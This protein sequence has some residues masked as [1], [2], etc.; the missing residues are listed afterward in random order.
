MFGIPGMGPVHGAV[1]VGAPGGSMPVGAPPGK[2]VFVRS[3]QDHV[4]SPEAFVERARSSGLSWVPILTLWQYDVQPPPTA[5]AQSVQGTPQS[6]P[7]FH[8]PFNQEIAAYAAAL[9][10]A[11][12]QPWLWGY[13]IARPDAIENFAQ[14]VGALATQTGSAGIIVDVENSWR[15]IQGGEGLAA[16]LVGK[17]RQ[18]APGRPVGIMSY[19]DPEK[20]PQFPWPV[21]AQLADFGA[22]QAFDPKGDQ[23]PEFA[24]KAARAYAQLGFRSVVP[25]LPAFGA[26]GESSE[27]MR[28][29]FAATPAGSVL[30]WDWFS[31]NEQPERWQAIASAQVAQ[32]S[33]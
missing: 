29:A 25:I 1:S 20:H 16:N 28:E 22:P 24:V 18:Y 15:Q 10:A 7:Y 12:I 8:R 31:A 23:G 30:W 32:V 11:G 9:L 2:G 5:Q 26:H 17:L 19:A 13:A 21:F 4:G 27:K 3:L 33:G 14:V 6:P